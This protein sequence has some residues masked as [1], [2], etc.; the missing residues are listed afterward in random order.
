M[1]G[2]I[3]RRKALKLGTSAAVSAAIST[4]LSPTSEVSLT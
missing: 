1:T 2:K 3:T 4:Q